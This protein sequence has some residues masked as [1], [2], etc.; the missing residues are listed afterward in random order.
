MSVYCVSPLFF[1]FFF[2]V[3]W[4]LRAGVI[5]NLFLRSCMKILFF[6]FVFCRKGVIKVL[7]DTRMSK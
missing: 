2:L 5:M 6:S 4:S 7:N 1:C 3:I